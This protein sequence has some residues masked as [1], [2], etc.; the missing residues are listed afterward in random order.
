MKTKPSRE[1]ARELVI[2]LFEHTSQPVLIGRA[3]VAL[4]PY[5]SLDET[6]GVFTELMMRGEI[7]QLTKQESWDLD[8]LHGYVLAG[9]PVRDGATADEAEVPVDPEVV[10]DD[11]EALDRTGEHLRG[12]VSQV[13]ATGGVPASDPG[14]AE[15]CVGFTDE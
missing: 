15:L 4:G 14:F 8:V 6:E 3:T 1:Q 12:S 2:K 9:V 10:P 13:Q 5:W 7:R 11:G